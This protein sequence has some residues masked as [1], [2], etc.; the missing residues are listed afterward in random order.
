M[1]SHLKCLNY[2]RYSTFLGR[3]ANFAPNGIPLK[4]SKHCRNREQDKEWPADQPNH[5]L[6]YVFGHKG[7]AGN[8]DTSGD[9]M[10]SNGSPSHAEGILC[11]RQRNRGEEGTITKLS[12]KDEFIKT[13]VKDAI[14][15]VIEPIKDT[16]GS[17]FNSNED[18]E[19][20]NEIYFDDSESNEYIEDDWGQSQTKDEW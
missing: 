19:Y 11:G 16:L 12:R 10:C 3:S 7:T 6:R 5:S 2:F 8:G 14:T 4:D 17:E 13:F 9:T 15:R 20:T 18:S 1:T